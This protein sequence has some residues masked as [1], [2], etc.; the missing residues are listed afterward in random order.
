MNKITAD[1]LARRV[2]DHDIL[3][4]RVRL[5]PGHFVKIFP[6][7]PDC[8]ET[9]LAVKGALRRAKSGR[10]LDLSGPFQATLLGRGERSRLGRPMRI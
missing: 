1:H 6:L 10:A 5:F 4:V 8:L 7:L 9:V 3:G 2:T